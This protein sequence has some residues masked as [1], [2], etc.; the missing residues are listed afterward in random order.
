M[1]CFTAN[2]ITRMVG[3]DLLL[4]GFATLSTHGARGWGTNT[5]SSESK[6]AVARP[7]GEGTVVEEQVLR[8]QEEHK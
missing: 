4:Q 2:D 1:W 7:V 5:I 3:S 8:H 6:E